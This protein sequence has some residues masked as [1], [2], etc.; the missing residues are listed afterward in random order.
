MI[1]EIEADLAGPH[2]MH[3]LL[4]GDVGRGQDRGGRDGAARRRAG[5]PPGRADGADRGAGRA[6]R[7]PACARCSATS[8]VPDGRQP[9]RRPAA[10]GRAAHEPRH[11]QR[12]RARCSPAWPT[13]RVDIAIGTHALIQ[14]GVDVPPPRR[15]RGRRAAPLRRRAAG[16]AARQ[17]RGRPGT[18]PDVLVMTATPIPRTAAMTVYGDLDVS[19]L[20]ELPPGRTPITHA[21]GRTA[22]S[23]RRR[24][25]PTCAPR[26][27]PATRPT[28]C[29]R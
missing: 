24:C 6:A 16:R 4:Q 12:A 28:S 13:A 10:A 2:P 11:R 19:V 5:R 1:A 27:P 20:D 15:R 14:E 25:G 17:G 9:L 8:T 3:R 18:V 23:T 26:W 22:R 7:T 29:A 21:L